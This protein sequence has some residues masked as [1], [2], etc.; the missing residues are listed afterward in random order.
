MG[1][2]DIML[3][4]SDQHSWLSSG[5]ADENIDTPELLRIAGEGL[6]F[7][8]C[9]CNAPLCVPS[10]MSFLTG[11]LPSELDVFNNDTALPADMPT[12]AHVLGGLGYRTVLIGRMHFKGDE[13]KHG[14]DEHLAGDITSQYWGTG[15]ALRDGFGPYAGTTNRLHCLEQ[16]GGGV[17]PVMLYDEAVFEE[18]LAFLTAWEKEK[19]PDEPLFLVV[20]FYGPHF[21]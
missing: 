21:P 3:V 8:H 13:Q 6:R 10:R 15:G 4:M 2:R 5:F 7:D 17:S 1:K 9:Y 18:T 16:V 14:F 12:I 19:K 20:G 11:L